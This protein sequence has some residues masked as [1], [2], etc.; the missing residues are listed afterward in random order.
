MVMESP[1]SPE[2][3]PEMPATLTTRRF[4]VDEYYRMAEVGILDPAERVELIE[5]EIVRMAAIGSRHASCVMRTVRL[6][7][8]LVG[9]RA[10]VQ[11]QNPV[12]LGETSEPQ[13]DVTLLVPRPDDYASAHPTP[14]QVLLAVEVSDTTA[15]FDREVKAPLYAR[16]GVRE[17]WL[18][19]LMA[20]RIE[21]Y[22]EPAADG[23]RRVST[24]D[25]AEVLQVGA[26]PDLALAVSDILPPRS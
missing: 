15:G 2:H 16:A 3:R 18:V 1:P 11:S 6:L 21:V 17:L 26:L 12:R 19:D 13:P 10:T 8:R 25:R 14:P 5:G 4:N 9:D 7:S 22:R 24:R 20:D 23:Y